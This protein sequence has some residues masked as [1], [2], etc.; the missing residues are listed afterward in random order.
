MDCRRGKLI[1]YTLPQKLIEDNL[2][3]QCSNQTATLY[4]NTFLVKYE[5]IEVWGINMLLGRVR[6]LSSL[7]V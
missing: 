2:H 4:F 3:D 5:L 7:L 1:A 6:P